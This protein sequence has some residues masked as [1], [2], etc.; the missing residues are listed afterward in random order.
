[1]PNLLIVQSQFRL[2]KKETRVIF[3]ILNRTE[4]MTFGKN[5]S[6]FFD[7]QSHMN[8]VTTETVRHRQSMFEASKRSSL[9][10]APVLP[11]TPNLSY[12]EEETLK[13]QKAHFR[14]H[15]VA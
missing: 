4:L 3:F 6:S 10:V 15:F 13:Y 5:G 12:W 7:E 9:E 1:M 8:L 14:L 2:T 11:I